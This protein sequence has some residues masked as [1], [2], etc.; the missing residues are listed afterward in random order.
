M[1]KSSAHHDWLPA[2]ALAALRQLG[3]NLA[4]GRVR[5]K[6]SLRAWAQR[7]GVSVRTVQRLEAGDPGVGMGVYA[8]A[9]W[10]VGRSDALP[11]L[12]DPALDRG[13]L[14]LDLRVARN[15]LARRAAG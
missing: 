14:E 7:L 1:P 2:Q 5:R 12:A 6:E 10:L 8:A 3:A 11:A 13:A 9:L 4:L 15:R